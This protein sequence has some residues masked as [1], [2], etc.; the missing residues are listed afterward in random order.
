MENIEYKIRKSKALEIND[1]IQSLAKG[2]MIVG[3]VAYMP[4]AI[5]KNSD[6]DLVGVFDFSSLNFKKLYGQLGQKYE[7]PVADYASKQKFNVFSIVWNDKFEIQLHLWDKSAFENAANL[8][9]SFNFARDSWINNK[10]RVFITSLTSETIYNLRG[11]EKTFERP[12]KKVKGGKI[13][14]FYPY[15]ENKSD[16]YLGIQA[17]NLISDP[18]ILSQNG[19][20]I[21]KG[22][23]KFKR[24]LKTKLV[25][26]Y[27]KDH[28][29]SISL[30]NSL[31]PKA[32]ERISEDLKRRLDYFF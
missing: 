7:P 15:R 4:D 8:K 18:V 12:F 23:D 32:K 28:D 9:Y 2:L 5:R 22:I 17:A 25:D 13:I 16:F 30:Y 27:G 26:I 14:E 21:A 6:L 20:Y 11:E 3:S 24:N 10:E 29:N 19:G 31:M 1:N